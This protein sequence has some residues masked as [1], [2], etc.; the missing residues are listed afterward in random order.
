MSEKWSQSQICIAI[1]D[2]SQGSIAK[3]LRNDDLHYCTFI[4]QSAGEIICKIGEHLAKL[5]AKW[6][7][8]APHSHCTFVIK[9]ADFA[10]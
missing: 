1:N 9:D 4:T 3:H 5:Q 6:L 7:F 2:K 10:R 8:H